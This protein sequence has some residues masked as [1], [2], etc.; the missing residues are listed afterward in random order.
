[1]AEIAHQSGTKVK[2][3]Q[4]K[5]FETKMGKNFPGVMLTLILAFIAYLISN[6][7]PLIAA[8]VAGIVLG[9]LVR[10]FFDVP[11]MFEAGIQYSLKKILKYAIILLGISI[12]LW[13][14]LIIGGKSLIGILAVV[15]LGIFLTVFVGRWLKLPG[16]TPLLVG[17]GTAICGATAIATVSPILKSKEEETALAITTIFIFNAI[18]IVVYPF[19]GMGL[20][21]SDEIFGMWAGIAIHDTSSVVAA[22]YAYSDQAG[23]TAT[24][25]KLTRTL[26]LL[27]VA[28]IIGIYSSVKAKHEIQ[29]QQKTGVKLT[30]IFPWFLLGF[31]GMSVLNTLGLFS[32]NVVGTVTDIS[33]FMIVMAMVG[34]GFGANFHKL[35]KIGLKPIYLGLFASVVVAVIS[36]LI[37]YVVV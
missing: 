6:Q 11:V 29:A 22:A 16:N 21:M 36:I 35:K 9:M 13:Q 31:L 4:F 10:N 18:A 24:V 28:I 27:P 25:V 7:I 12:N 37:I 32:E 26:F 5:F 8:A 23:Q 19:L 17:V 34:V 20:S 33:K 2:Q 3:R 14:V 15:I 30:K 1:M